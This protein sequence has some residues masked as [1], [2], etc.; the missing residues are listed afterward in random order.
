MTEP[1]KR[2]RPAKVKEEQV[3]LRLGLVSKDGLW[4][5]VD[6]QDK[7]FVIEPTKEHKNALGRNALN[8]SDTRKLF[9]V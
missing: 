2:G 8:S 7:L 6:T 1:K 3:E 5:I 4:Q 9:G